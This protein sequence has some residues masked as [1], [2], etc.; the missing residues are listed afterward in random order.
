MNTT[1]SQ[2]L[3]ADLV[4]HVPELSGILN[5][6]VQD[7][8]GVLPHLFLADVA[9]SVAAAFLNGGAAER[10]AVSRILEFFEN[11][12]ELGGEVAEVIGVS[13]V[14]MLPSTGEPASGVRDLLGPKLSDEF[15][16]L[17]W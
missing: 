7:N 12:L 3:V 6:H 1:P 14:E 17:N 11:R 4:G 10:S 16:G 15:R 8:D 5:E 13:F 9:R 2:K